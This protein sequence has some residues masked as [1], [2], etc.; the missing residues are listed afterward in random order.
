MTRWLQRPTI[1]DGMRKS[2]RFSELDGRWA[3]LALV[4]AFLGSTFA[5]GTHWLSVPHRLCEVHGTIE[6]GLAGDAH[7]PASPIPAGPIVREVERSHDE[8]GLGPSARTE[9]MLLARA[10]EHGRFVAED[11]GRVLVPAAPAP[12]LQ[13]FLLAPSRSP[14]V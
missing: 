6:H 9:A 11:C 5:A 2:V 14:P 8:C 4:L 7:L 13:L 3:F 1:A 12:S 10:E